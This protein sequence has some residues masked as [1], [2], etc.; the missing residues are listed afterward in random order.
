MKPK[1]SA[2]TVLFCVLAL[3]L[4]VW[5][6]TQTRTPPPKKGVIFVVI[7]YKEYSSRT[8]RHSTNVSITWGSYSRSKHFSTSASGTVGVVIRLRHDNNDSVPMTVDTEGQID[9]FDQTSRSPSQWTDARYDKV[10]W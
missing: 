10:D 1:I 2:F 3:P 9:F 6:D 8:I 7:R 4:A 5:A